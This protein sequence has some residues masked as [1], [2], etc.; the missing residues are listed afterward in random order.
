M[1]ETHS[2]NRM[3]CLLAHLAAGL[4]T[5][6]FAIVAISSIMHFAVDAPYSFT[7][8]VVGLLFIG[9]IF[10]SL[11]IVKLRQTNISV[12]IIPD[13]WS[14]SARMA[15]FRVS[16]LLIFVFC[17]WFGKLALDYLQIT[18]A[19]NAGSAGSQLILWPWTAVMPLSCLLSSS[20][21]LLR[22]FEPANTI[23]ATPSEYRRE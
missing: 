10:A 14:L 7:E 15:L 6:M 11:P 22:L 4:A 2:A 20:A 16:W 1:S 18:L 23:E 21:A 19:L 3:A 13:L 5:A 8:E 12:M 17:L 9:L